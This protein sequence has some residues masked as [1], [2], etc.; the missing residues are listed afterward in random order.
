MVLVHSHQVIR[1]FKQFK[2]AVGVNANWVLNFDILIGDV[3][4]PKIMGY[5]PTSHNYVLD[6][7]KVVIF[8]YY[9]SIV[10]WNSDDQSLGN[11]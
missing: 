4:K 5:C 3:I 8:S 6:L 11:K 7:L 9:T 2:Q 1:L 10:V